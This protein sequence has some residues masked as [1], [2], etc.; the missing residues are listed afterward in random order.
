MKHFYTD[1]CFTCIGLFYTIAKGFCNK[2]RMDKRGRNQHD[3]RFGIDHCLFIVKRNLKHFLC[4]CI[5]QQ[6][7][8]EYIFVTSCS[9]AIVHRLRR[10]LV[11]SAL[12]ASKGK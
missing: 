12:D 7:E 5:K 1:R 9:A 11:R 8:F 10:T 6:K 3:Y 4:L 2:L